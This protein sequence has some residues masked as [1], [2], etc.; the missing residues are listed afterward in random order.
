M[1]AIQPTP[2]LD[3]I[4]TAARVLSNCL[5]ICRATLDDALLAILSST[6]RSEDNILGYT[7]CLCNLFNGYSLILFLRD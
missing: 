1:E 4:S 6:L 2:G 5:V 7:L 3:G